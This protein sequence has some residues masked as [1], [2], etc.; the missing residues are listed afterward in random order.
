MDTATTWLRPE[1]KGRESELI[2]LAAAADLVGVTRSTVSNWAARHANFPRIVLLTGSLRKRS[3]F[4]VREEFLAFAQQQLNKPRRGGGRQSAPHRPKAVIRASQVENLERQVARLTELA[5][6]RAQAA[7]HS[8]AALHTARQKLQDA[9]AA[10]AAE[11]EAVQK[12]IRP[13]D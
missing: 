4:V 13:A 9:R 5:D 11:V 8:R 2:Q 6:R 12:I 7:V 10:L 3:K 1:F